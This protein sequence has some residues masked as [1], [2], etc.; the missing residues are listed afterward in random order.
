MSP[1]LLAGLAFLGVV[2]LGAIFILLFTG[3]DDKLDSR[4]KDL[5]AQIDPNAAMR[6]EQE[7]AK[8]IAKGALPKIGEALMSDN[9]SE[10]T[11]LK[12]RMVQAGFY[13]QS[14]PGIFLTVKAFCTFVPVVIGLGAWGL[15]IGGDKVVA[16]LIIGAI[17]SMLGL[18]GPSFWLDKRKAARQL[19]LRRSLPD[20][21]DI[22]VICLEGGLALPAAIARVSEELRVA[23][24]L[25]AF[26]LT[27]CQREIQL[28]KS[29]GQALKEF[30]RRSDLDEVRSLS[31]VIQQA[32]KY[33]ASMAKA[34][35]IHAE[36]L[37]LKRTQKA[38]EEAA[39]A[40]TKILFPTLLFIFP[41]IFV[42][43]LGPAA[44]QIIAM[45]EKY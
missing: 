9:E 4:V 38:E 28:G 17:G 42:V 40:G 35:R 31:A 29:T 34:L 20:A 33:G 43:I 2:C 26:E 41:A 3:Q 24:T 39:K 12:S 25:L 10:R 19:A 44:F 27:I 22:M 13:T 36:T 30:S 16:C 37:R 45:F 32:E 21:M 11:M 6:F 23:H 5:S 14:A 18:I 7:R 8:T 15:G 1:L